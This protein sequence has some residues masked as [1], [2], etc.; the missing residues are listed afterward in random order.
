M[1]PAAA[2]DRVDMLN[3]EIAQIGAVLERLQRGGRG[4]RFRTW[5]EVPDPEAIKMAEELV[6]REL[7]KGMEVR[8]PVGGHVT[9]YDPS[10]YNRLVNQ[11]DQLITEKRREI[12]LLAFGERPYPVNICNSCNGLTGMNGW[13]GSC[14]DAFTRLSNYNSLD[15]IIFSGS[16]VERQ[17]SAVI[18]RGTFPRVYEDDLKVS[19]VV[20]LKSLLGSKEAEARR[21]KL[22]TLPFSDSS[23]TIVTPGKTAFVPRRYRQRKADSLASSGD[24][25]PGLEPESLDEIIGFTPQWSCWAAN[26][27]EAVEGGRWEEQF[28][29]Q[30]EA[31][32]PTEALEAAW[33]DF[34][35]LVRAVNAQLEQ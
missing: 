2:S 8:W 17:M 20:R 26:S 13:C 22:A 18:D 34:V 6:G 14:E 19:R 25:L 7:K 9:R 23:R 1:I 10:A 29:L 5:L 11:V 12:L 28:P 27:W 35:R 31:T 15:G 21:N 3:A 4:G 16:D 30:F 24:D 32:L 33:D